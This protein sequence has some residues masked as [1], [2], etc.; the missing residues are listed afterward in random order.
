MWLIA[1]IQLMQPL[2][3]QC[4]PAKHILCCTSS[5]AC[6]SMLY[7]KIIISIKVL[8]YE[9]RPSG[10]KLLPRERLCIYT[11][12]F[13]F[14]LS[15]SSPVFSAYHSKFLCFFKRVGAHHYPSLTL[16]PSLPPPPLFSRYFFWGVN[17][18]TKLP[19]LSSVT[20]ATAR[21]RNTIHDRVVQIGQCFTI[22]HEEGERL[23]ELGSVKKKKKREEK[24]GK[25]EVPSCWRK[26][27]SSGWSRN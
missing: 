17:T 11:L 4:F 12:V 23:R 16:P 6:G 5:G 21:Q 26:H 1:P 14:R 18:H 7:K 10:D 19:S 2:S 25:K 3:L 15:P 24:K 22:S 27:G 13:S 20:A 9:W 8:H